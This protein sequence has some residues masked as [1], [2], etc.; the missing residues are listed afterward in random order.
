MANLIILARLFSSDDQ[1]LQR[2]PV[3][4]EAFDLT[5]R[6]WRPLTK[7]QSD[8]EGFIKATTDLR[9]LSLENL[10]PALRLVEDGQPVRVL[11][12][13][14][15][16][17]IQGRSLDILADFGE[18]ECLGEV[19]FPRIDSMGEK[20]DTLAGLARKK[21]LHLAS[22]LRHMTTNPDPGSFVGRNTVQ[23]DTTVRS[24]TTTRLNLD[25]KIAAELE[26]MHTINLHNIAKLSE[27]DR[28][29]ATKEHEL[30]LTT[31]ELQGALARASEA[32]SK[33]AEANK[34]ARGQEADIEDVFTNIG[35]KL[36]E[37]NTSLKTSSNP[38]RIGVV[39][40]DLKG[41]LSE[42][43]SIRLGSDL[44]DGSGVSVE[45]TPGSTT[46]EG[47]NVIVPDVTGLT[48]SAVHRVLRSVGLRLKT[49]SQ[50]ARQGKA[51]HGQSL[52]Q[53]PSAGQ[54]TPHGSEILVVFANVSNT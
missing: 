27:K 8:A 15:M 52:L 5:S 2:H 10:G 42:D 16:L 35:I 24:D 17:S 4:I 9:Q 21:G 7:A 36:N 43:G 11:S 20:R 14:P 23:P 44:A 54:S 50:S 28:I 53:T 3:H 29:I 39:K 38:F 13:G 34:L 18:I 30:G 32:E 41:A 46:P 31:G 25:P 22:I 51:V 40:V 6:Q 47:S 19:G 1:A 49:A 37:A 12:S 45:M 26:S 33:L 48:Q